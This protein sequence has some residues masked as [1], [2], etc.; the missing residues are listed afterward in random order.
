MDLVDEMRG[1]VQ[2]F[3][4][5]FQSNSKSDSTTSHTPLTPPNQPPP[6]KKNKLAPTN[7]H[8]YDE[9][10]YAYSP[11][12]KGWGQW[13]GTI[14]FLFLLERNKWGWRGKGLPRARGKRE[15]SSFWKRQNEKNK[16]RK[17][18]EPVGERGRKIDS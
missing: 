16:K 13:W 10:Q 9:E 17:K 11:S 12:Q 5:F 6:P 8:F 15:S 3:F 14:H 18:R 7:Q 2:F 1:S 4:F